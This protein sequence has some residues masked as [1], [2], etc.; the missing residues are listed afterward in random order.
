MSRCGAP[1]DEQLVGSLED[2][3][4]VA[5]ESVVACGKP[6]DI[7]FGQTTGGRDPDML[8]PEE[9]RPPRMRQTKDRQLTQA[10]R[11]FPALKQKG[12][13]SHELPGHGG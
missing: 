9:R 5:V 6:R 12:V 8:A 1:R 11:E 13:V 4:V 7:L 3:K 10:Q 2:Q